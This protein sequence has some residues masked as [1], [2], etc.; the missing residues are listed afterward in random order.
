MF[1]GFRWRV[2]ERKEKSK[3]NEMSDFRWKREDYSAL[4]NSQIALMKMFFASTVQCSCLCLSLVFRHRSSRGFLWTRSHTANNRFSSCATFGDSNYQFL[5]VCFPKI[6]TCMRAGSGSGRH[7]KCYIGIEKHF[8]RF[9]CRCK[10]NGKV[11][12]S[13]SDPFRLPSTPRTTP[14][15]QN[16]QLNQVFR[17]FFFPCFNRESCNSSF[18]VLGVDGSKAI[19]WVKFNDSRGWDSSTL[20]FHRV[21]FS[22]MDLCGL[23]EWSG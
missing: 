1:V 10:V 21:L 20:L 9:L 17:Y 6:G 8:L 12:T 3:P 16:N 15:R 13:P 4:G 2:R 23:G 14:N 22:M 5:V 7:L 11:G 18:C 19:Q